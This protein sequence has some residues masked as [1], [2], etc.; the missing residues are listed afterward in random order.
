MKMEDTDNDQPMIVTIKLSF[1]RAL[2]LGILFLFTYLLGALILK[3]QPQM[4]VIFSY[5][6]I[7]LLYV[8]VAFSLY[9]AVNHQGFMEIAHS[10]PGP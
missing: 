2:T 4:D 9:F 3:N 6:M 7:V 5:T 1:R 8:I 10:L